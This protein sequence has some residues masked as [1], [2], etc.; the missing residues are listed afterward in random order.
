MNP[1]GGDAADAVSRLW[2]IGSN[3]TTWDSMVTLQCAEHG[4]SPEQITAAGLYYGAAYSQSAPCTV[5]RRFDWHRDVVSLV[6]TPTQE[7][8]SM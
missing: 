7:S 2:V 4:V 5:R 8:P 3:T 6:E 1:Q